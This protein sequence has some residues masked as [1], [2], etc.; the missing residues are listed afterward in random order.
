[1]GFRDDDDAQRERA[2]R[3]E[4]ELRKRNAELRRKD[5]E[6]ERLRAAAEVR[7]D[8]PA[9]EAPAEPETKAVSSPDPAPEGWGDRIAGLL[10][11]VGMGLGFV[12]LLVGV[13]MP[14]WAAGTC[15]CQSATS[16]RTGPAAELARR[17]GT[18]WVAIV[19]SS[20]GTE[21]LPAADIAALAPGASCAVGAELASD[22][23]TNATTEVTITCGARVLFPRTYMG[24]GTTGSCEIWEGA[25]ATGEPRFHYGLLCHDPGG[26][27]RPALSMSTRE[28]TARVLA[29]PL[30]VD[31]TI[32][33]AS[34]EHVGEPLYVA[35]APAPIPGAAVDRTGRVVEVT[36]P[37]PHPVGAA[38]TLR[39]FAVSSGRY[40]CMIRLACDGRP[41][42]GDDA[43]NDGYNDCIQDAAGR[44][45]RASD[46]HPSADD[47][48]PAIEL[49]V[50]G[51][52]ARVSD[53]TNGVAW[54]VRVTLD[55]A[56][57]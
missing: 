9:K 6:L 31:L 43:R 56:T 4:A 46:P 51:G 10:A 7:G 24:P 15:L 42:Y 16:P 55:G 2:E 25:V 27:D 52:T 54:T 23:A 5:A 39:V 30:E 53:A 12:G 41:L 20:R 50:A 14:L 19:A 37:A 48:D 44:P 22:G 45:V 8:D 3:L 1:M 17:V 57:E 35:N 28:G 36:G 13:G 33:R 21:R 32:E 40:D 26:T 47:T 49:D 11:M 18:S 29:G 34:A 38:C